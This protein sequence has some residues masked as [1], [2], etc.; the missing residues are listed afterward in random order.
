MFAIYRQFCILGM[1]KLS[2]LTRCPLYRGICIGI[3][4]QNGRD[5]P[6][7]VRCPLYSMSTL[8]RFYFTH[9]ASSSFSTKEREGAIFLKIPAL[10]SYKC[11][12]VTGIPS[13]N[14]FVVQ[15]PV[16]EVLKNVLSIQCHRI[17][18]QFEYSFEYRH[19]KS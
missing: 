16:L 10:K 9:L 6:V 5:L 14:L 19:L 11:V 3:Y 13:S 7:L 2:A 8:D 17:C 12:T 18:S 15:A 4:Q 1:K